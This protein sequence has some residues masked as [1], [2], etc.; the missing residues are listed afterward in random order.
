[1]RPRLAMR[2]SQSRQF[3]VV[4]LGEGDNQGKLVILHVQLEERA[5]AHNLQGGQDDAPHVH[6][7]D[8]HVAG[9]LPDVTEE[10]QVQVLILQPRQLQV[11]IHVRAVGIPATQLS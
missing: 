7:R 1:M 3:Q 10:G 5:S 8:E 4:H 9:H 2:T 11:P 6:V